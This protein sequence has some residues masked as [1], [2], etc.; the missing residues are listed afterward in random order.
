MTTVSRIITG[1]RALRR[2]SFLVIV[3][4]VLAL[5]SVVA[6][7][8]ASLGTADR[9]RSAAATRREEL[10]SVP[11]QVADYI[12]GIVAQDVVDYSSAGVEDANQAG[13]ARLILREREAWDYPSTD[14][15]LTSSSAAVGS[16]IAG[17][18]QATLR[19]FTPWGGEAPAWWRSGGG[20]AGE[21]T[22]ASDP[23]LASAM[24]VNLGVTPG[25][26][27]FQARLDW[28][29]ISNIAPDGRFVNLGNLIGNFHRASREL[30]TNLGLPSRAGLPAQMRPE[31]VLGL[32]GGNATLALDLDAQGIPAV[33]AQLSS[34][35]RFVFREARDARGEASDPT[36]NLL[37]QFADAD[38]DGFLDARWLELVDA[39]D[40]SNPINLL[41]FDPK[42][43]VFVAARIVDLS[44]L[45]NVNTAT[46]FVGA[47][48]R[49]SV[50]GGSPGD[51]DLR[52]VM[53]GLVA[54]DATRSFAGAG[55]EFI[56]GEVPGPVNP[57]DPQNYA[58]YAGPAPHTMAYDTDS[59]AVGHWGYA[60]LR[61]AIATG[62]TPPIVTGDRFPGP[63]HVYVG[64]GLTAVP[65]APNQPSQ[66][67]PSFATDTGAAGLPWQH[68]WDF[69][70]VRN[71]YLG[72]APDLGP[73]PAL[74]RRQYYEK[75]VALDQGLYRE[76][77]TSTSLAGTGMLGSFGLA[78]EF[79]L[80]KFGGINDDTTTSTL[81]RTVGGRSAGSLAGTANATNLDE[82]T[83]TSPFSPLRDN[84]M[85]RYERVTERD[86]SGS[87]LNPTEAS[88]AAL[89]QTDI[90]RLL[91]TTSASRS[92]VGGTLPERSKDVL[93]SAELKLDASSLLFDSGEPQEAGV[94]VGLSRRAALY[95]E[96]A[97]AVAPSL[98]Q[99]Q[100]PRAALAVNELFRGYARALLG[101]SNERGVWA[102][103]AGI[104]VR[105]RTTFYGHTGP[106]LPL[107]MA[108]HLAVNLADMY[109]A[110]QR[111]SAFT[112]LVGEDVRS[113]L[114]IATPAAG[115]P[116][117]RDWAYPWWNDYH[118]LDL[119]YGVDANGREQVSIGDFGAP[120]HE[121][122]KLPRSTDPVNGTDE[123]MTRA[124]NVYGVEAFPFLT[125]A[126][127]FT[128]YCDG[129]VGDNGSDPT[130]PGGP[131]G[132][133]PVRIRTG[134]EVGQD[135]DPNNTDFIFRC[136]AFQLTN[137]FNVDIT[138]GG[139]RELDT[140]HQTGLRLG[141]RDVADNEF[142]PITR[143]DDYTYVK[144]GGRTY[145]LIALTEKTGAAGEYLWNLSGGDGI[146]A[147]ASPITIRAGKSVVVFA[148]SQLPRQILQRYL[149]IDG[150][151]TSVEANDS[152]IFRDIIEK[153]LIATL[154]PAAGR[155]VG[156]IEKNDIY[157]IPEIDTA[158]YASA[159]YGMISFG[160]NDPANPG[161]VRYRPLRA[162]IPN[163]YSD[164]LFPG[165]DPAANRVVEL[166]RSLRVGR[167]EQP[168][169]A[170]AYGAPLVAGS[171]EF[172]RAPAQIPTL[173]WDGQ[174]PPRPVGTT[175]RLAA[176]NDEANDVMLDRLRLPNNPDVN[177]DVRLGPPG[178]NNLIDI[179]DSQSPNDEGM[180]F[181]LFTSVR[182]PA[183]IRGANDSE[184]VP[185]GAIPAYCF[186]RKQAG[187]F[188]G[189]IAAWNVAADD[190]VKR[191]SPDLTEIN[192]VP[193]KQDDARRW[194][195]P[196]NKMPIQAVAAPPKHWPAATIP[197]ASPLRANPITGR[198]LDEHYP[199]IVLDDTFFTGE[200]Q[201]A[202]ARSESSNLRVI[203]LLLPLAIGPYEDPYFAFAG[204]TVPAEWNAPVFGITLRDL[205][206]NTLSEM[207]AMTMG[208]EAEVVNGTGPLLNAGG[209]PEPTRHPAKLYWSFHGR[210]APAGSPLTTAPLPLDRGNLSIDAYPAFEPFGPTNNQVLQHR[211]SGAPIALNV[212]D[213]FGVRPASLERATPGLVN[214]NTMPLSVARALPMLSPNK[215]P[216]DAFLNNE[217]PL[218][219]TPPNPPPPKVA[220]WWG[221]QSE[222]PLTPRTRLTTDSDI[223][224]TLLSYRDRVAVGYRTRE[225]A[226]PTLHDFGEVAPGG[227]QSVIAN[228]PNGSQFFPGAWPLTS[229][230]SIL[231]GVPRV[232]DQP[233]FRSLGEI[234]LARDR[235]LSGPGGGGTPDQ[236]AL[237]PN[238]IDHLAYD[239]VIDPG[240]GN[241]VPANSSRIGV[242]RGIYKRDRRNASGVILRDP[243]GYALRDDALAELPNP[244]QEKLA[245]AAGPVGSATIRSDTF[246][247][248]FVVHAYQESD[249]LGVTPQQPLV[250]SIARRF[251]MI[252]DRSNVTQ[253]GQKPRVLLFKEVPL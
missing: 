21:V 152:R 186:E 225:L 175:A 110:D 156:P 248:W 133:G 58:G 212:L 208:F 57:L 240:T 146:D 217:V 201:A 202:P 168:D 229:G 30:S 116:T 190:G 187:G 12:A 95:P 17:T 176:H 140:T 134:L 142:P 104:G 121:R 22:F 84:R 247:V 148:T 136:V 189:G 149:Q 211:G 165:G 51:V 90:R 246:A 64:V 94:R 113:T 34:F 138:L 120:L 96:P 117:W 137:P 97:N 93:T 124:V 71:D 197:A 143:F 54:R 241:L 27:P 80:R 177:M 249:V 15:S 1:R 160:L 35:Q 161:R 222:F 44:A 244:Y 233:G 184:S 234:L 92:I 164:L 105:K 204:A 150:S 109:D 151:M 98:P 42:Y 65:P 237:N 159:N 33:P 141:D 128:A 66:P 196:G 20:G 41:R 28:L 38:G 153:H 9:E 101:A 206:Y 166:W 6:I 163:G 7:L 158:Q 179:H 251:V 209:L 239:G 243:Q 215:I 115:A 195:N 88:Y 157:W 242:T 219:A 236:T 145:P 19:L 2:G 67:I 86:L 182:R 63:Q 192:N 46:D 49:T 29:H 226:A 213:V 59:M 230:R 11:N 220:W 119:N 162:T 216:D 155:T 85:R 68:L 218:P 103:G 185:L 125:G 231:S 50:V 194:R 87:T 37:L 62:L 123:V 89:A 48:D 139:A 169:P 221:D 32:E 25:G 72:V 14:W 18:N 250:P 132:P 135:S 193:G 170:N 55:T 75:R 214:V 23:W 253:K 91:T 227:I 174:A 207:L 228:N 24:P 188:S 102:P 36:K 43:R 69:G 111:P 131:R 81:E 205:R 210:P 82:G 79:E 70:V 76:G 180:T 107:H 129:N 199:Q 200:G 127:V 112:L 167:E 61:L 232:T 16:P 147:V 144:F 8:Y 108:A 223:A 191:L 31:M 181:S 126:T 183:D 13:A 130:T 78:D 45:I 53:Q 224:A 235:S 100:A 178:T 74:R 40:P 73:S 26:D 60:A 3:V 252:L 10:D 5:L 99:D 47:P 238:S 114:R 172:E 56:Y 52:S 198:Q 83:P 203:D 118:A 77:A 173:T 245:L 4:G 171:Y 106:E 154:T 39:S 122:S